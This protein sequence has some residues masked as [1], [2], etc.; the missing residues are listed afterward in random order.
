MKIY[1]YVV[2]GSFSLPKELVY[3]EEDSPA[4]DYERNKQET[5][6]DAIPYTCRVTTR[7]GVD[8]YQRV[9]YKRVYEMYYKEVNS[10][11]ELEAWLKECYGKEQWFEIGY[12][13]GIM[14]FDPWGE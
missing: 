14:Q 9:K 7:S 13:Q 6:I 3:V 5:D 12:R 8:E 2:P 10:L 4:W 1:G 11:E